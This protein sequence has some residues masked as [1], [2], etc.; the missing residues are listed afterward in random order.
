MLL[1]IITEFSPTNILFPILQACI[2]EYVSKKQLFPILVPKKSDATCT[3]HLSLKVQFFPI[4]IFSPSPLNI[5][6][7]NILVF[8]ATSVL[9]ITFAVSEIKIL[10]PILGKYFLNFKVGCIFKFFFKVIFICITR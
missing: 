9:P 7:S 8:S 4:F 1:S 2:T 5:T 6:L 3:V 10:L